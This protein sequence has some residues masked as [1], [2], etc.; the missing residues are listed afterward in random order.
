M[1]ILL[2]TSKCHLQLEIIKN[3]VSGKMTGEIYLI[4]TALGNPDM[5]GQNESVLCSRHL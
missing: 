5:R 2:F 3:K 1:Q 4:L